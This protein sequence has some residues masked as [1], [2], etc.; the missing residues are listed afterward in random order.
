MT[1]ERQ[2]VYAQPG[3]HAAELVEIEHLAHI[4]HTSDGLDLKLN[5]EMLHTRS[6]KHNEDF[7]YY[8]NGQLVGYLPL[9]VFNPTEA[10]LSGMVHPDY[11]RQGVFTQLLHVAKKEAIPRALQAFFFI[12]EHTS[13]SGQAFVAAQHAHYHHSEYKMVLGLSPAVEAYTPLLEFRRATIDEGSMLAHMTAVAFNLNEP[14]IDWYTPQSMQSSH[15]GFYVA[16]L[17]GIY[18]G[19]VDVSFGAKEAL[20]YG[21]GVLPKHQRR[22]YGKQ[23]LMRTIQEILAHGPQQI[24]LEVAVENQH[25]L[26]LYHACGFYETSRYDYYRLSL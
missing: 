14:G 25:A 20:I 7:L 18:V 6:G 5:W 15:Q 13:Q 19:K 26:G 17:N 11:R 12:V 24:T 22:G 2:G 4:C 21:F 1:S 16:L 10:E 8:Q 9:F 23:I 3:L